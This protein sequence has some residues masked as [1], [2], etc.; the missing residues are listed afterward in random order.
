MMELCKLRDEFPHDTYLVV[1]EYCVNK[2]LDE[3]QRDISEHGIETNWDAMKMVI[4][5]CPDD[6]DDDEKKHHIITTKVYH[7]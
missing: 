5:E 2:N 3:T 7:T 1:M 4:E 6:Q